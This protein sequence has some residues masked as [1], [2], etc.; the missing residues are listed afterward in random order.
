MEHVASFTRPPARGAADEA[1][2]RRAWF[3]GDGWWPS[4]AYGAAAL[5]VFLLSGCA[6]STPPRSPA[7][8]P[9]H[10]APLLPAEYPAAYPAPNV[11]P[12]I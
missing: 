4:R 10:S 12:Q 2:T 9:F 6:A 8:Y 5:L 3:D 11:E 1:L 7:D